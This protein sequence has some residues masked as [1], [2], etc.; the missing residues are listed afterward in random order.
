MANGNHGSEI[1]DDKSSSKESSHDGDGEQGG[2]RNRN[3]A[4]SLVRST[5]YQP[6][7]E[8]HCMLTDMPKFLVTYSPKVHVAGHM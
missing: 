6:C 4:E 5:E 3:G 1:E 7:G 8:Y 2:A